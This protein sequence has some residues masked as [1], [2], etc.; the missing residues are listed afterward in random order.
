MS[1]HGN[2]Q[3]AA[4]SDE[5]AI[6]V[7][8]L[9]L[10]HRLGGN[11]LVGEIIDVFIANAPALIETARAGAASGEN[12]PVERAL[13]SLKSSA[14]QLGAV[15]MQRLCSEGESLAS[16]GDQSVL[17]SLVFEI[18]V[19]FASARTQLATVREHGLPRS[20]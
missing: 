13:H 4:D 7:S 2:A 5:P 17:S 6:R 14:G 10:L 16:H 1:A 18:E 19:E 3:R 15:R 11:K 9:A 20:G 12:A 8:A